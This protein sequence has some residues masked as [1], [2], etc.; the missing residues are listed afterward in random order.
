MSKIEANDLRTP[1]GN[2]GKPPVGKAKD[3]SQL[4]LVDRL[5]HAMSNELRKRNIRKPE[6]NPPG[7][8]G[9]P[10]GTP[11]MIELAW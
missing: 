3:L 8:P 1:L 2:P 4:W 7:P 9:P 10:E 6:G 11:A 5:K